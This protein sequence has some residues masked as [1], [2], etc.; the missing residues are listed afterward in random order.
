MSR[1]VGAV[2]GTDFNSRFGY[3]GMGDQVKI[4]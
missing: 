4:V 2:V 1:V 3:V